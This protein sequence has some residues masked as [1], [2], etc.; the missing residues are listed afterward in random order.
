MPLFLGISFIAIKVLF[1]HRLCERFKRNNRIMVL[2]ILLVITILLQVVAAVAAVR[3]MKVTKYNSAW[4]LFSI[5]LTLMVV[6]QLSELINSVSDNELILPDDFIAWITV[7]IALSIVIGLFFVRKIISHI[8]LS[9]SK[10]RLTQRRI[11]NT[12]I[13]TE[14]KERR[15]FS[16]D[17]HDGLGPLLSSIKLSVSALSKV[18]DEQSRKK[19]VANVEYIIDES[20]KSLKEVSNNISPHILNNFGVGRAVSTFINK[21]VAPDIHIIFVNEIKGLRFSPEIEAIVYRVVCELINNSIKHAS[22]S[23]IEVNIAYHDGKILLFVDDDGC[24]FDATHI[25]NYHSSG[26]GISN[27]ASRISSLKGEMLIDSTNKG[28]KVSIEVNTDGY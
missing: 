26:M 23:R 8:S 27:I 21:I 18:E 11:L 5:A 25:E 13:S 15:R 4:I 28:T 7:I 17:L 1:L 10:S 16:K 3:L 20:I 14:E 6:Q 22:A 24:G 2:K 9:E 19:I 12:I